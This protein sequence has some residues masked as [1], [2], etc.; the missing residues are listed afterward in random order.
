M[1]IRNNRTNGDPEPITPAAASKITGLTPT[2]LARLGDRG[3]LTV[4]RPSG[5]HRRYVRAEV[6]ALAQP[7]KAGPQ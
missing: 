1:T 5:T 4:S 2:Q 6:E 3:V 7:I